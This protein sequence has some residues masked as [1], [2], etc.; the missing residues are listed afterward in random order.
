VVE[1]LF[2]AD[3]DTQNRAKDAAKRLSLS[4]VDPDPAAQQAGREQF[5]EALDEAY[6]ARNVPVHLGLRRMEE[7]DVDDMT[8][9]TRTAQQS[10]WVAIMT[11]LDAGAEIDTHAAFLQVRDDQLV[12]PTLK[13]KVRYLAIAT[14]DP[15][16]GQFTASIPDIPHCT[17]QGSSTEHAFIRVRGLAA[18]LLTATIQQGGRLPPSTG[19]AQAVW[20]RKPGEKR[21]DTSV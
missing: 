7:G 10:A 6:Q 11:A 18:N 12:D 16:T 21:Q 15:A 3:T 9:A 2:A 13:G 5:K 19:V 17:A 20:V 14:M 4:I 1:M 8:A